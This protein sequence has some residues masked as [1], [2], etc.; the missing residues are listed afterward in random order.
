MGIKLLCDQWPLPP[1]FPAGSQRFSGLSSVWGPSF[2]SFAGEF[3]SAWVRIILAAGSCF[4]HGTRAGLLPGFSCR[5]TRSRR[6]SR[7]IARAS[8]LYKLKILVIR[9]FPC[10]SAM[11]SRRPLTVAPQMPERS[12]DLGGRLADDNRIPLLIAEITAFS[13][14]TIWCATV[15]SALSRSGISTPDPDHCG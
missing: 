11:V 3:F 5:F 8:L 7:D 1:I 13:S 10:L 6:S 14:L 12:G 4:F 9:L 15:I 2:Q